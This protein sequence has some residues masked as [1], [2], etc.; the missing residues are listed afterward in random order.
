MSTSYQTAV[1]IDEATASSI[2]FALAGCPQL[3]KPLVWGNHG[4]PGD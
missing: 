3:R 1:E 2:R 4:D